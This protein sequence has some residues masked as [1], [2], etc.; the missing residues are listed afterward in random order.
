MRVALLLGPLRDPARQRRLAGIAARRRLPVAQVRRL[1]Q[2]ALSLPPRPASAAPLPPDDEPSGGGLSM[3]RRSALD[4]LRAQSDRQVSLGQLASLTESECCACG[5]ES[6]PR[7]C[8]S[9]RTCT[10][11]RRYSE[12]PRAVQPE[13]ESTCTRCGRRFIAPTTRRGTGAPRGSRAAFPSAAIARCAF[14]P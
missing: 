7:Y 14:R 1:V 13:I 8:P 12:S 2:A 3:T 9:V 4:G 6:A 11:C 5:L 10:C